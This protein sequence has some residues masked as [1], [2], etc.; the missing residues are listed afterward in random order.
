MRL[1]RTTTEDRCHVLTLVEGRSDGLETASGHRRRVNFA[2]TVVVP[3]A[4]GSYRLI[5]EGTERWRVVK[6]FVK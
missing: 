4:A 5:N 1:G 6:A 2:E 3:A